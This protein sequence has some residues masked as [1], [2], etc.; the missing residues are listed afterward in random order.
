MVDW[1]FEEIEPNDSGHT[2]QYW[3]TFEWADPTHE[4]LKEYTVYYDRWVPEGIASAFNFKHTDENKVFHD[5]EYSNWV[6]EFDHV[7]LGTD[8]DYVGNYPTFDPYGL[9]PDK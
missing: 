4:S 1:G 6:T 2:W 3:L 7:Y 5:S 9:I 8:A